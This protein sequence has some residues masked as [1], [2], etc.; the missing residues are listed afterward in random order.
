MAEAHNHDPYAPAEIAGL[1]AQV[2]VAKAR[3]PLLPLLTLAV[4]GGAHIAFGASLYSVAITDS[5]LGFGPTQV[6]GGLAFSLGLVLIVVGGAELFTGNN[7]LA[8]AWAG[9]QVSL[10]EVLR[11]WALVY[12]GN[13]LGAVATAAMVWLSGIME[14]GGGQ[15]AESVRRLALA[16]V[17]LP[18]EQV[19]L[20]G[21]LCNMLVCLAIWLSFAARDVAGRILAIVF[22]VTAFVALGL[23]HS[24]ANMFLLPLGR[25]L[26]ADIPLDAMLINLLP[27]TLGNLLGGTVLVALVY[28]VCYVRPRR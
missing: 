3:L 17:A 25:L 24:V 10:G 16:K 19:F 26:G 2:G 12:L 21:V 28:Y 18:V 1:V 9:G 11:N 5:G 27:A 7:L 14:A 8:M 20:R 13:L 23:E 15:V 6:L 22:P 4:L